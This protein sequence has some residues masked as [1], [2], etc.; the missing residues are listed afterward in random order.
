MQ[1]IDVSALTPGVVFNKPLYIEG[2][3]KIAPENTP[4]QKEDLQRL[5]KWGINKIMTDGELTS[6]VFKIQNNDDGSS[7]LTLREKLEQKQKESEAL[8]QQINKKMAQH[9]KMF[10]EPSN[11]EK[12]KI[13]QN[14]EQSLSEV[15]T[16]LF[17]VSQSQKV[18]KEELF[19]IVDQYVLKVP[20]YTSFF[21]NLVHSKP[22]TQDYLVA[23][24]LNT[25]ILS[26]IIGH[27]LKFTSIK[28][29][30]IALAG[31]LHDV[32]MFKIPKHIREKERALTDND[33]NL[34]KAHTVH[35]YR[36]ILNIESI[37]PE[38]ALG[39]FHHHERWDGT[40]YPQKL[41]GEKIHL[42]G[43]IVAVAQA[44]SAMIKK[45]AY[46]NEKISFNVMKEIL[47]SSG[48]SFDPSIVTIFLD[49]MAIFP[50][51][52]VLQLSNK[53]IGIVVS[54]NVGQPLKPI[55]KLVFDEN[56]KRLQLPEFVNMLDNPDLQIIKI[57]DPKQLGINIV[58]E[59]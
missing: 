2:G 1:V 27:C 58:D 36:L 59:V 6:G 22:N 37:D 39:A 42:Y 28:L 16:I 18:N 54:S 35:T 33:I 7:E 8:Q 26:I 15:D 55:V 14:Y 41:S 21:I 25:M 23:Q 57:F 9:K 49:T 12:R 47:K 53:K 38:I 50:I 56:V 19:N 11:S 45:R 24:A 5:E 10:V 3:S 34:I 43:R 30:A 52:S 20:K 40:G 17:K 48:K 31:L 4:L 46:R 44:Y 51:G 29:R 13:I 32:G